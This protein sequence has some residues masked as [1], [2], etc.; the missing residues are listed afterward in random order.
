MPF[1]KNVWYLAAWA[2]ELESAPLAR[3]IADVPVAFFRD[4]KGKAA[5]VLDMC[6]HRFAPLSRGRVDKGLLV[7]GYHGLGFGRNGTCQI[8][9]HGPVVSSLNVRAFP[10]AERHA[11]L[12]VWL[13]DPEAADPVAIPDLGFIDRTPPEARVTGYLVNTANYLLMVDNI[14]D[15]SHADYLHPDTLGGG[16]NT[17]TKGKVEEHDNSVT[18]RWHADDEL[19]PP[20]QNAFLPKPGQRADFRN[21]VTWYPPGVMAQR[22]AFGPTGRLEQDG[23]ESMTAH[24]MTPAGHDQTHYFFCHTSDMLTLDPSL[25]PR[26]REMLLAAFGNEDAPMLAAQH[27]RIGDADFWALKPTL[28]PIDTGATR[29]RRRMDSLIAREQG[30]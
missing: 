29:V 22:L 13:G 6:P 5:A 28:L 27:A 20:V 26:I 11:A 8:N 19:L 12:W 10:L 9:P 14:M 23:S 4:D 2:D 7:C 30:A 3:T 16:V 24:V 15:L 21:E 18:I 1:L 17:R 25:A